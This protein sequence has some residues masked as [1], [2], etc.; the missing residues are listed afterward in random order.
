MRH[1]FFGD[2]DWLALNAR[3]IAPPFNPCRHRVGEEDTDNF[4][5][6]FTTMPLRSI[7]D[8]NIG[9]HREHSLGGMSSPT[10]ENFTYEEDN[11]LTRNST[12]STEDYF[13]TISHKK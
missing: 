10:F 7:D 12:K 3:E 2:I 1:Q 6:T 9:T 13:M 4:E 8:S 5:A 11:Y